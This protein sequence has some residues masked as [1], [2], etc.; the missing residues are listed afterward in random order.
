LV[1]LYVIYT[2]TNVPD[3]DPRKGS[4]YVGLVY[5]E[6]RAYTKEWCGYILFTFDTA[7]FFCVCPVYIISKNNNNKS[8]FVG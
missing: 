2:V 5:R 7:P 4:K 1:L 3:D 8:A 6:Y